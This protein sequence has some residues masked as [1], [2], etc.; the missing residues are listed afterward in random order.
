MSDTLDTGTEKM[1]RDLLDRAYKMM[2]MAGYRVAVVDSDNND[3]IVAWMSDARTV[4]YGNT[5]PEPD[6]ARLR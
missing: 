3:P 6:L 5:K 4:L 2:L 1:L